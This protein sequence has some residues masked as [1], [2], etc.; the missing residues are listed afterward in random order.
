[1]HLTICTVHQT[2]KQQQIQVQKFNG[3][4][5]LCSEITHYHVTATHQWL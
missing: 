5:R 3:Q 1:M 2:I 4:K